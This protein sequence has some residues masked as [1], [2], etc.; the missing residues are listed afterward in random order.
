[1]AVLVCEVRDGNYWPILRIHQGQQ[2]CV[3]ESGHKAAPRC[4][5]VLPAALD[6][7]TA[8]VARHDSELAALA[9]T[10]RSGFE[11]HL[12]SDFPPAPEVEPM[13]L[14][15]LLPGTSAPPDHIR[16]VADQA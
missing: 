3:I 13:N 6:L 7:I 10:F 14:P 1:M 2:G 11:A 12:N 4:L 16:D 15:A 9:E 8:E 5:Q